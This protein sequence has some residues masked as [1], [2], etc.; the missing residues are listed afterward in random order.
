M[1]CR[2]CGKK[3][4][5]YMPQHRLALCKE[6]FVSWFERY[7]QRTIEE[8]KMFTREDR[9]LVAVSG[10]KDSLALWFVLRKLGYQADGFYLHLGIG[11]Y[12]ERSRAKVEEFANRIDAKLISVDLTEEMAG[13]PDL[14]ILTSRTECSL[15]G[16]VKRYN[17]NKVAKEYGYNVL[18][19]G[20][21]LDDE[22]SSLFSNVINWN[23]KY[24]GRK[25]PVLEEEE[26]FVRKVKPFCKFT[27]KETALYS[28]LNGIDFLEEECPYSE[29]AS[30]IFYK[31]V[32][33]QMEEKIPGT[34]MRFY[35]E[36]LRK[37]YPVFRNEE[38][39]DLQPCK[40]CGEPSPSEICAVCRLKEKV[41]K[42]S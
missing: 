31:E 20:H 32:L 37:V 41:S 21:N 18:A 11:E 33:N 26:G 5:I 23:V 35:L 14:K 7:T 19:T 28:L 3:P 30:T 42:D 16:M 36:Y 22:A 12:S 6:D 27:E 9:V 8:F 2:I 4:I 40:V 1:K 15:C 29:D 38:E 25:Y 34:K 17:F 10:G 24:L 13:I 39:R